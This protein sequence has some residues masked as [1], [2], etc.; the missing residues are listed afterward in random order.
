MSNRRADRVR[1]LREA[2]LYLVTDDG[3]PQAQML[4]C[5]RSALGAGARVVQLRAKGIERGELFRLAKQVQALCHEHQAL[6]IVN[7][8]AD[9]AAL[10]AADGLHLGQDDLPAEAARRLVPPDTLVGVSISTLEEARLA[11]KDSGVDY[12]GVGAMFA[13]ETKPNAEYGGLELLQA[14]RAD[15]DLP[16]VAIG[17]ITVDNAPAV[18]VAGADLVAVVSAVFSADDPAA[19]TLALLGSKP[20]LSQAANTKPNS[21]S[22]Y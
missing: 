6:F 20:P 7:D 13:T 10:L 12:L 16:L 21:D 15:V 11:A 22:A 3:L 14:V 8:A 5:L 1:R 2:G 4:G 19:A 17:G 18:W 9:V